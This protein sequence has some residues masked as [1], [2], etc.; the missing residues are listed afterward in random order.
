MLKIKVELTANNKF[1]ISFNT[2]IKENNEYLFKE[3]SL[4]QTKKLIKYAKRSPKI[5]YFNTFEEAKRFAITQMFSV[6]EDNLKHLEELNE[7]TPSTF[8]T[9]TCK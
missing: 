3:S 5:N 8:K 2:F 9:D 1:E 4:G 6:L 7:L